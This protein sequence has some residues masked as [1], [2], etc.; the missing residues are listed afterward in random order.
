MSKHWRFGFGVLAGL[1]S[2]SVAF[3]VSAPQIKR[4]WQREC[5]ERGAAE[6]V[7]DVDDGTTECK[8]LL[9]PQEKP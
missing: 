3:V 1:I 4:D 7:R 9:E 8:W 2:A 5:V 6:W